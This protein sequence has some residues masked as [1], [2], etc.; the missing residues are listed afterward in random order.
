MNRK[1]RFATL[2]LLSAGLLPAQTRTYLVDS[3]LDQLFDV[4]L[5]TGIR[6]LIGSTANNGLTAP[7]D[8]SW[9]ALTEQLWTIDADGGEIG[10]LDR[11][12]GVF[13][14][15]YATGV[16]GWTALAWHELD[17]R[18]YLCRDT[19]DLYTFFPTT[20]A[21]TLL[22]PTGFGALPSL[23]TDRFGKLL[24]VSDANDILTI[25]RD[26]GAAFVAA[27]TLATASALAV[28]PLSD[29]LWVYE[30][31][32][33]LLLETDLGTGAHTRSFILAAGLVD[34]T[35]LEIIEPR[36]DGYYFDGSTLYSVDKRTFAETRIAD[37][38]GFPLFSGTGFPPLPA[39]IN[40]PNG[41]TFDPQTGE[42]WATD[43][44]T[45]VLGTIDTK[46]GAF[47]ER[48]F[49][50]FFI[51]LHYPVDVAFDP[52]KQELVWA[53]AGSPPPGAFP[54]NP[55]PGGGVFNGLGQVGTDTITNIAGITVDRYGAVYAARN[56]PGTGEAWLYRFDPISEASTLLA[57]YPGETWRDIEYDA[58]TDDFVVVRSSGEVVRLARGSWT[59]TIVGDL[60][61]SARGHLALRHLAP[62]YVIDE[63]TDQLGRI[64]LATGIVTAVGSMLGGNMQR[65][66]GLAYWRERGE[67]WTVDSQGGEVGPVDATTG[68]F[69]TMCET[70]IS[71]F[72]GIAW[73]SGT[74]RFYLSRDG[75]DIYELDPISGVLSLLG[76]CGY[77][78]PYSLEVDAE[79]SLFTVD[80]GTG[81]LV[82]IDLITGVGAPVIVTVPQTVGLGFE[83]ETSGVF[84]VREVANGLFRSDIDEPLSALVGGFG[85]GWTGV[86]GLQVIETANATVARTAIVGQACGGLS[87]TTQAVPRLESVWWMSASWP[88]S[89]SP[90]VL[91]LGYSDPE[92]SLAPF[93]APGCEIRTLAAAVYPIGNGSTVGFLIPAS[94]SLLGRSLFVQAAAPAPNANQLGAIYSNGLL[95]VI[96]W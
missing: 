1:L 12:D 38:S 32:S 64:D 89:Q 85:A 6:S 27:S 7:V 18:F 19:G 81:M 16:S 53:P 36:V 30:Q 82:K 49:A 57:Q 80:Y 93:G 20:N 50:Q 17:K 24:A 68:T 78:R 52:R 61:A 54:P 40:Q 8:L 55:P 51:G 96:G 46:T 2:A 60:P 11:A 35:G 3:G 28:H 95:G 58:D 62:A 31:S 47:T 65:P 63:A 34:V 91:A 75:G 70:G 73:H 26:T 13:T 84:A 21:L 29:E 9:R 22:G 66:S 15:V 76:S 88:Q 10:T 69:R 71:G 23:D 43:R 90:L 92:F 48:G 5:R 56:V 45:S 4:S 25:D 94:Q 39:P 41:I 44:V 77:T 79:G 33:R 74:Q 87:L 67:L 42:L 14:P 83:P 59:S 86:R 72:E 37:V